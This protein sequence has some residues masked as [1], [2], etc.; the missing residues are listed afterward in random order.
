LDRS[1]QGYH[2][3]AVPWGYTSQLIGI[4][5]VGVPDPKK[6][7]VV[8]EMF[9]R[10]GTWVYSDQQITDWLNAQRF[11]TN[12]GNTFG[13]D[14]VRDMLCTAYYVGMIRYRWMTVRPKGVSFRSKPPQFSDGQHEPKISEE[15]WKRFQAVGASRRATVKTIKKTVWVNLFQGLVICANFGRRLRIQPSK[16]CPTYYRE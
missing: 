14:A 9:E 13:K 10:Y 16:N 2:N 8:V 3:G 5:K 11:S 7:R 12:R 6:T 1:L 4:R 15:L